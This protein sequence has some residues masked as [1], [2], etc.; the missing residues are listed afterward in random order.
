M[1]DWE[2]EVDDSPA[3]V[4]RTFLKTYFLFYIPLSLSFPP[5]S[6]LI[7]S[8]LLLSKRLLSPTM[9]MALGTRT[10]AAAASPALTRAA[11]AV[12][13]V[14][15]VEDSAVEE[16]DSGPAV[17]QEASA[18]AAESLRKARKKI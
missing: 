12:D 10:A 7:L 9:T 8:L 5:Y 17:A 6:Q 15:L 4:R 3:Q 13:L 14:A 1:S 18:E 16:V 2:D 11:V